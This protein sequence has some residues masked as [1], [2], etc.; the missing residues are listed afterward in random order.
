MTLVA[1]GGLRTAWDVA[2]AIALGADAVVIGTAEMVAL[3]CIRCA[4]C[5]S[6]R[7]C[8]RG[9]AT[10]DP[11]LAK[12]MELDWATQR[13][14]NLFSSWTIQLKAILR[15]YGMASVGELV[16]RSDLLTHIDYVRKEEKKKAAKSRA[17]GKR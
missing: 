7:G 3:E 17:G 11:I 1:S 16:G 4:A 5:E 12:T 8:P 10:T 13:L 6:G 15:M 9:I 2:K 14:K